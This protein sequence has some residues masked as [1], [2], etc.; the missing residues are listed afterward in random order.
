MNYT[1][2]TLN[3][4]NYTSV[5]DSECISYEMLSIC[6]AGT[7]ILSELMPFIQP[8]SDSGNNTVSDS[9]GLLHLIYRLI[10]PIRPNSNSISNS[11]SS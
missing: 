2:N 6:M 9:N 1:L 4:F 10:K 8:S 5:F 11:N 7:L 3:D